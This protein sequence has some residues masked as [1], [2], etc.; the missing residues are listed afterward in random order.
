[1]RSAPPETHEN[2]FEARQWTIQYPDA[3]AHVDVV[4]R[5]GRQ[6]GARDRPQREKFVL[7]DGKGLSAES[8]NPLDAR[9][10]QHGSALRSTEMTEHIPRK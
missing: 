2:S 8:H 10:F 6:P 4:V 7:V 5:R 1:M 3:L 9:R